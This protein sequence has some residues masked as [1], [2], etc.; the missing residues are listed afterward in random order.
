MI[1]RHHAPVIVRRRGCLTLSILPLLLACAGC[2]LSSVPDNELATE[3]PAALLASG[4]KAAVGLLSSATTSAPVDQVEQ[5]RVACLRSAINRS[6]RSVPLLYPTLDAESLRKALLSLLP[7]DAWRY[8]EQLLTLVESES[9]S[10]ADA[11]RAARLFRAGM[12][13]GSGDAHGIDKSFAMETRHQFVTNARQQLAAGDVGQRTKYC[14][15]LVKHIQSDVAAANFDAADLGV[16]ELASYGPTMLPQIAAIAK[17]MNE[18]YPQSKASLLHLVRQAEPMCGP[19]LEMHGDVIADDMLKSAIDTVCECAE[20]FS[21]Q[22]FQEKRTSRIQQYFV[23]KYQ[24]DV[25]TCSQD[26]LAAIGL[27]GTVYDSYWCGVI[28]TSRNFADMAMPWPDDVIGTPLATAS[29]VAYMEIRSFN[30]AKIDRAV[31]D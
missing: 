24:L 28:A 8:G 13:G 19:V 30:C 26:T 31:D 21:D 6:E 27:A 25:S 23:S 10:T 20:A 2:C 4:P 22:G 5:F 29:P 17:E 11:R 12:V 7:A 1:R 16:L 3:S 15:L 14:E 18:K 9:V